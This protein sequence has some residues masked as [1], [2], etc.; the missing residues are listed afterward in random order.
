MQVK[1]SPSGMREIWQWGMTCVTEGCGDGIGVVVGLRVF[2]SVWKADSAKLAA[3]VVY[4]A[5]VEKQE[6][7]LPIFEI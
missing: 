3:L 4:V 7:Q 2:E 6:Q 5:G 1:V